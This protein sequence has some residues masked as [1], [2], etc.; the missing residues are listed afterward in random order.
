MP[1]DREAWA[2][3]RRLVIDRAR[4]Q[5]ER[6]KM[7]RGHHVHHLRYAKVIGHEPLEWLLFVCLE[8]HGHFHPHHTFLSIPDQ[9]RRAEINRRE[10]ERKQRMGK[11]RRTPP[12]AHCGGTYPKVKHQ[13]ICVKHGLDKPGAIPPPAP[14]APSAPATAAARA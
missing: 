10:R 5:C 6:C 2:V 4:G 7:R 11:R 9:R 12:C 3:Q 14:S 8:C 1:K 13:A